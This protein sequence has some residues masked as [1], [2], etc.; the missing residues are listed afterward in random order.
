M[1][2]PG[3]L[4][5]TGA[6][7]WPVHCS[8]PFGQPPLALDSQGKYSLPFHSLSETF[9]TAQNAVVLRAKNDPTV[10]LASQMLESG[11][12]VWESNLRSEAQARLVGFKP[13]QALASGLLSE[14]WDLLQR[15]KSSKAF[16]TSSSMK[17]AASENNL[18]GLGAT[19]ASRRHSKQQQL[20]YRDQHHQFSSSSSASKHEYKMPAGDMETL[21]RVQRRSGMVASPSLKDLSEQAR[22]LNPEAAKGLQELIHKSR[23][24]IQNAQQS[25]QQTASNCQQNLQVLSN[26]FQQNSQ[27]LQSAL[28][29]SSTLVTWSLVNSTDPMGSVNSSSAMVPWAVFPKYLR[30]RE[31]GAISSSSADETDEERKDETDWFTPFQNYVDSLELKQRRKKGC[32]LRDPGR[33]VAIVTTASLPWL[34]GTSVNPLLRAAYMATDASRKITLVIPWLSPADQQRVFPANVTFQTPEDQEAYVREWAKRRTGL[35]CNFKVTFYPGRY[36]AEKGGC[37][38]VG[39]GRVVC[40]GLRLSRLLCMRATSHLSHSRLG[41]PD[42]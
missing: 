8:L 2:H 30:A 25:I 37:G 18:A 28:S 12:Q 40:R 15:V 33:Q 41:S 14:E 3:R 34:T 16:L 7:H 35:A 13:Q 19:R 32:S 23:L 31:L 27:H 17:R 10:Q 24:A 36:A 4:P 21:M 39:W 1:H 29:G 9:R 6:N 20:E 22:Q 5:Q 26:I 38:G 42:P 11:Y